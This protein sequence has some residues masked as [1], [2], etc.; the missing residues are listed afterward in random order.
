MARKHLIVVACLIYLTT[1]FLSIAYAARWSGYS[2][3]KAASVSYQGDTTRKSLTD[4]G[5]NLQ[6]RY[7]DKLDILLGY[8]QLKLNAGQGNNIRQNQFFIGGNWFQYA[9]NF[10]GRV[11]WHL[12]GY[13]LAS[14]SDKIANV[15]TGGW[16]YLNYRKTIYLDTL[17]TQSHYI[18]EQSSDNTINQI[19]LALEFSPGLRSSWLSLQFYMID[20]DDE[21]SFD[22]TLYSSNIEWTQYLWRSGLPIPMKLVFGAQLGDQRYLVSHRLNS[23]NNSPDIQTSSYWASAT[24]QINDHSEVEL[25][26]AT[27]E[28]QTD[29]QENYD[30]IFS[31]LL[32]KLKW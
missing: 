31:S 9:D 19:N 10:N 7:L 6:T 16:S 11:G 22:K 8:S 23:I 3:V 13:S 24:W 32:L 2:D 30:T 26:I 4:F 1:S 20:N 17:F 25:S 12:K 5:I 29:Q 18:N 27:T 14:P 15:Y 21:M 28:Y